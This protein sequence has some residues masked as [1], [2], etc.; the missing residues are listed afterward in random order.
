MKL[1]HHYKLEFDVQTNK[2]DVL[3]LL[4]SICDG[5]KSNLELHFA[6]HEIEVLPTVTVIEDGEGEVCESTR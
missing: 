2:E 6:A 1:K 4:V 5:V 3:D